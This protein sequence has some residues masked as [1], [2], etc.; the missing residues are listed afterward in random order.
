MVGSSDCTVGTPQPLV[1]VC[2][3]VFSLFTQVIGVVR[4]RPP[5]RTKKTRSRRSMGAL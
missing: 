5:P 3:C 2:V 4:F 1:R